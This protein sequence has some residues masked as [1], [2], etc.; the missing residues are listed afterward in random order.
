MKRQLY[1]L[2]RELNNAYELILSRIAP[3]DCQNV[4]HFLQWLAF[5]ARPL[6]STEIVEVSGVDISDADGLH[7]DADSRYDQPEFL[8]KVCSELVAISEGNVS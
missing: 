2:P 6:K 8:L 7:F 4:L 3:K 5:S 1:L